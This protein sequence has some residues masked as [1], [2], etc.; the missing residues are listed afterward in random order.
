MISSEGKKKDKLHLLMFKD[1]LQTGL[2]CLD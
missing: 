1:Y 2:D